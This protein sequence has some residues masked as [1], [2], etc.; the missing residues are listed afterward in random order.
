MNPRRFSTTLKVSVFTRQ[1]GNP[2]VEWREFDQGPGY[3]TL[4][5]S[6]EGLVSVRQIDDQDLR[7]LV[8]DLLDAKCVIGLDLSENRKVTDRGIEFLA[9]LRHLEILNLSSCDITHQ[10]L[11]HLKNLPK[12]RSLDISYCNRL[13]ENSL[14]FLKSLNTLDELNIK[15]LI[16]INMA[17]YRKLERRGLTIIR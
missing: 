10:G 7:G 15:G 11:L 4:P 13:R 1:A 8:N 2:A 3:F 16:S 14:K 6:D 17:G 9:M 12:L 5:D